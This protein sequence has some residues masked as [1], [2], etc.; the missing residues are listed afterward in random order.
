MEIDALAT[1]IFGAHCCCSVSK[2]QPKFKSSDETKSRTN[3]RAEITVTVEKS[4]PSRR[5]IPA[6][7]SSGHLDQH[8]FHNTR[9]T[10]QT[11]DSNKPVAFGDITPR[12]PCIVA[13]N[14]LVGGGRY[15]A[16]GS[17]NASSTFVPTPSPP[18]PAPTRPPLPRF[19]H[20]PPA[21]AAA[22]Q[23]FPSTYSTPEP[24]RESLLLRAATPFPRA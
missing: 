23:A 14:A 24:S 5:P 9:K 16:S 7:Q 19:H 3:G 17:R 6:Y 8:K 1:Q 18:P 11:Y 21:C 4:N 12:R 20:P 10:P 22:M 2:Q 15:P 13:E